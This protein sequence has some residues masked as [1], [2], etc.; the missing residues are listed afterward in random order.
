M[1]NGLQYYRDILLLGQGGLF[2]WHQD[3]VHL[4]HFVEPFVS[5]LMPHGVVL[6]AQAHLPA[7]RI[8]VCP[9]V[10]SH[11]DCINVVYLARSAA[12]TALFCFHAEI[13][14]LAYIV[15]P[16]H[17]CVRQR[18]SFVDGILQNRVNELSGR[19]HRAVREGEILTSGFCNVQVFQPFLLL[20]RK[21]P[22]V[23]GN[24]PDRSIC[25]LPLLDRDMPPVIKPYL[26]LLDAL[27]CQHFQQ[28]QVWY[29]YYQVRPLLCLPDFLNCCQC[30]H[31]HHA[32]F[33][34]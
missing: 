6:P 30:V 26:C 19:I 7:L 34:R 23:C 14:V 29:V 31:S 16:V 2:L 27:F 1:L 15:R 10:V 20:F 22:C 13:Q 28:L 9:S 5:H 24:V 18:Y 32:F 12:Y 33:F 4:V 8:I 21:I 3:S 25:F 17:S 11:A